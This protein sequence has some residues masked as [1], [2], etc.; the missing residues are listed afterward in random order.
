[1]NMKAYLI[2]SGNATA[3]W[4]LPGN[5]PSITSIPITGKTRI[6]HKLTI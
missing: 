6:I 4:A 3:V 2:D 5:G 1:M